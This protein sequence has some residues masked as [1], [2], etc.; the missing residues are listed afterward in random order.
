LIKRHI[1]LSPYRKGCRTGY[2]AKKNTTLFHLKKCPPTS[3]SHFCSLVQLCSVARI[4]ARGAAALPRASPLIRRPRRLICR[5]SSLSSP[6]TAAA[7]DIKSKGSPFLAKLLSWPSPPHPPWP[8][9]RDAEEGLD[10]DAGARLAVGWSM[11]TSAHVV[12]NGH[13]HTHARTRLRGRLATHRS[14]EASCVDCLLDGHSP[15]EQVLRSLERA[16]T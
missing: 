11:V 1:V 10:S 5:S 15:S 13:T 7:R 2:V 4:V 3:L 16:H 12:L 6:S 9:G 14:H 8:D